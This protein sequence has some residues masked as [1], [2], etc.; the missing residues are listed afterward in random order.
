MGLANE[1]P[2]LSQWIG[3]AGTWLRQNGLLTSGKRQAV[4][5]EIKLNGQPLRWGSIAFKPDDLNA[6]VGWAMINNGKFSIPASSGPVP[7]VCHVAV[8]NM[9]AVAP[10]P[11]IDDAKA[12][13]RGSIVWE[14]TEGVNVVSLEFND[15]D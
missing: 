13:D 12:I 1:H 14:V 11:T 9:G 10:G 8:T 4:N 5:G 7:G 15:Q 2:A 6:P 3:Q